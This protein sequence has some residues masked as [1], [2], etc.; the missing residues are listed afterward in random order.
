MLIGVTA[1]QAKA[2]ALSSRAAPV[3]GVV[4][5]LNSAAIG[6][7]L[8]VRVAKIHFREAEAF[9]KGDALITFD[10]KRIQ[11][12][13][14]AAAAAS[15]ETRLTLQSQ[16]Y[17]ESRGAVGKLDVEIAKSRADKSEAE[18]AS[19]AARL[20]QCVIVAPFDGRVTEMKI[21]ENEVPPIGQPF[22]SLVDETKFEI[23]LILPS[24]A[25]RS[26]KPGVDFQFRID[27]TDAT[28]NATISRIGA[29]VD[30]VSQSIKAIAAFVA[31]DRRIVAGM[32]GTALIP[33]LEGNR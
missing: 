17:L 31:P 24:Q 14:A 3:R 8:A 1:L 10:C 5:A 30:P 32:S 2:E 25:L 18:A 21:N 33:C 27:E 28:Y 29:V 16:S 19:I 12:E 9:K 4:R 23:D 15:R 26:L 6:V 13:H 22:I 11:A 20:E 7:D